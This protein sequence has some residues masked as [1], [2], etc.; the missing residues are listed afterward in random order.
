MSSTQQVKKKNHPG[1]RS[2]L[3]NAVIKLKLKATRDS[4]IS[5]IQEAYP[6]KD[7]KIASGK[8]FEKAIDKQLQSNCKLENNIYKLKLNV[9]AKQIKKKATQAS[10]SRTPKRE[11]KRT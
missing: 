9:K 1:Y 4:I 7:F 11:R 10:A 8:K 6:S 5:V 2:M 3:I